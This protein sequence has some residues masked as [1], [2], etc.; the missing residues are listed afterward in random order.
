M[1]EGSSLISLVIEGKEVQISLPQ[2]RD[3]AVQILDAMYNAVLRNKV[4][5]RRTRVKKAE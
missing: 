2:A 3:L 1:P 5:P 4:S